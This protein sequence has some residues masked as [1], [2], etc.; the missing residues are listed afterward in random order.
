MTKSPVSLET[1]CRL[2]S[3]SRFGTLMI[4][5]GETAPVV[6]VTRA[7]RPGDGVCAEADSAASIDT[8][9]SGQIF[10]TA[11]LYPLEAKK[12]EEHHSRK[13]QNRSSHTRTSY[14]IR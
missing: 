6:A 13:K 8:K 2:I 11:S 7:V 14:V 3:V 1:V 4:A 9:M 10:M 12:R 5:P